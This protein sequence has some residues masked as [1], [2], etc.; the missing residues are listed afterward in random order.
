MALAPGKASESQTEAS[1][2]TCLFRNKDPGGSHPPWAH[3]PFSVGEVEP[4]AGLPDLPNMNRVFLGRLP[5]LK[6]TVIF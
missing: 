1:T 5:W 2:G 6:F 3:I 4:G